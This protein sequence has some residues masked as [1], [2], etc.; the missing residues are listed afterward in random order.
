MIMHQQSL[1][2]A[3]C[4][5]LRVLVLVRTGFMAYVAVQRLWDNCTSCSKRYSVK[6]NSFGLDLRK[7]E[8]RVDPGNKWR[9]ARWIQPTPKW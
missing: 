7:T 4:M 6:T 9:A 8:H 2:V 5:V 3:G 1:I